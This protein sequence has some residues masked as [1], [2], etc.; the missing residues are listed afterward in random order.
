MQG[1]IISQVSASSVHQS[2]RRGVE[3]T[4]RV[5]LRTIVFAAPASV[6]TDSSIAGEQPVNSSVI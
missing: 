2:A 1:V 6:P 5:H 4:I 3:I